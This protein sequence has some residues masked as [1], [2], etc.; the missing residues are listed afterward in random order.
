MTDERRAALMRETGLAFIEGVDLNRSHAEIGSEMLGTIGG[1][2][3]ILK[4]LGVPDELVKKSVD[5][6]MSGMNS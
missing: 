1:A 5:E 2:L 4:S 6:I 3:A